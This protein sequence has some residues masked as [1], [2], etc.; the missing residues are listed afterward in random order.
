[1]GQMHVRLSQHARS[2]SDVGSTLLFSHFARL[3]SI[4]KN[5]EIVAVTDG[6]SIYEHN[7]T[8]IWEFEQLTSQERTK[9]IHILCH[10]ISAVAKAPV[11]TI[12]LFDSSH[13]VMPEWNWDEET[14]N[15]YYCP[16][17][18]FY[19]PL[20]VQFAHDFDGLQTIAVFD[21]LDTS[22][23]V[24]V[25]GPNGDS[26]SNVD[27]GYTDDDVVDAFHCMA[28]R[29]LRLPHNIPETVHTELYERLG[30]VVKYLKQGQERVTLTLNYLNRSMKMTFTQKKMLEFQR[31]WITEQLQEII[32]DQN[33]S[34]DMRF[35]AALYGSGPLYDLIKDILNTTPIAK[36][37]VI[38]ERDHYYGDQVINELLSEDLL[39]SLRPSEAYF[40]DLYFAT[41]NQPRSPL[42]YKQ[43][44]SRHGPTVLDQETQ[45]GVTTIA[46]TRLKQQAW[47][48]PSLVLSLQANSSSTTPQASVSRYVPGVVPTSFFEENA[49]DHE[50][51]YVWI[52][53]YEAGQRHGEGEVIYLTRPIRYR[54][55]FFMNERT[56][57]GEVFQG[58][59]CLWSGDYLSDYP[60]GFGRSWD[61]TTCLTYLGEFSSG[62]KHGVGCEFHEGLEYICSCFQNGE[63]HGRGIAM[64][65]DGSL[66]EGQY[67][68]NTI[69]GWGVSLQPDG[70][71]IFGMWKDGVLTGYGEIFTPLGEFEY[72]I[73]E[74]EELSGFGCV[75]TPKGMESGLYLHGCLVKEVCDRVI[76]D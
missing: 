18:F 75:V 33:V 55:D 65:D 73:Y 76:D 22:A 57:R 68:G 40:H 47:S 26:Y 19:L 16:C 10:I 11:N 30:A 54:S 24:H 60:E 67:H 8:M 28:K 23:V 25:V 48:G 37:V 42:T 21:C 43:V 44:E 59:Q 64:H 61:S 5:I 32:L 52:G 36:S 41:H 9:F 4:V 74:E 1:M 72:G 13:E 62:E 14:V 63:I 51:N 58:D 50:N 31:Y 17:A 2:H 20:S 27:F 71:M 53:N 38:S 39:P 34:E 15:I 69:H 35:Y 49:G 7:E 12:L 3:P 56:G 70:G 45:D 66:S 6:L 46:L 29:H